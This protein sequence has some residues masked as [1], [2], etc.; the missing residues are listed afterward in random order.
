MEAKI[1]WSRWCSGLSAVVC[2]AA[3][4][5]GLGVLHAQTAAAENQQPPNPARKT[6]LQAI[7]DAPGKVPKVEYRSKPGVPSSP[8]GRTT[9]IQALRQQLGEEGARKWVRVHRL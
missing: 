3:V 2:S 1:R 6:V 4:M 8:T 7:H 9:V 5:F